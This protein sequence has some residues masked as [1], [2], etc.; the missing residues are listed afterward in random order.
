M[1]RTG[2]SSCGAGL[3]IA[4]VSLGA[5]HG[6]QGF[7]RPGSRR[8]SHSL[9]DVGSIAPL[10]CGVFPDQRSNPCLLH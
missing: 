6:L 5:G 3:L 10:A 2:Y 1:L 9:W 4:V 8:Q 7:G